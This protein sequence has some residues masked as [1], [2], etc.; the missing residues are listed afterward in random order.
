M[1]DD[2]TTP[3]EAVTHPLLIDLTPEQVALLRVIAWPLRSGR[4]TDDRGW[5]VWDGV[6][7]RF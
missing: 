1:D 2:I 6:R 3:T 5:P 4:A 7:R